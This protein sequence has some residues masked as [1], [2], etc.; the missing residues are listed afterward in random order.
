MENKK[1]KPTTPNKEKYNSRDYKQTILPGNL[2][3]Q[4]NEPPANFIT[5]GER[6]FLFTTFPSEFCPR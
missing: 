3:P 4:L 5:R 6:F 2:K 1:V